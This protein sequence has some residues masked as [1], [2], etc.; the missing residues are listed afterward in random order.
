VRAGANATA[1]LVLQ[2]G[3]L[4]Q[5]V[6]VK[7]D[8]NLIDQVSSEQTID[9]SGPIMRTIPLTGRREWSDVLQV[10]PGVASASSD[11]YGGQT[12]FVRGSENEN[13]AT[14]LD[15][16]D[17][18]SFLQNWPSNYISISTESLGDIQIK[19][20]GQDASSPAAMG[21][22][23]NIASPTGSDQFHGAASLLISPQSWNSNNT[24]GGV[25]ATSKALQPDF[26]LG[27]PIK[28]GKAWFFASGRYINRDDGISRTATQLAELQTLD[29]SFEPVRE[30]GAWLRISYQRDSRPLRKTQALRLG[31]IR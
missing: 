5:S 20:G 10:T 22:V 9:I 14:L 21:M 8:T 12:Y 28:K 31:P 26:S 18:G 24:P 11:A 6:E 27:G 19:T 23:I 3:A 29:P 30:S 4:T 2:V 16:A 15:G 1:D 25:S 7:G 17:I 13:Q